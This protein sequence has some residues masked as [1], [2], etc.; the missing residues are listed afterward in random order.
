LRT[1]E[2][3]MTSTAAVRNMDDEGY[4]FARGLDYPAIVAASEKV[5]WTVD[6]VFRDRWF[7]RRQPI[8]PPSWI[9]AEKLSFL[10]DR[11]QLTLNH[12]RAFSYVHL[13]GNFEE[14]LTPHLSGIV[15]RESHDDRAHLRAL[16]RFG[17]EE[18]KHQQLFQRAERALETSCG[19]RFA[20]HFDDAK[21]AVTSLTKSILERPPLARFLMVLALEWGTQRHY[22]ESV[23]NQR[24]EGGDPLYVDILKAHWA[25]EAQHTKTDALEIARLAEGMSADELSVAF[26]DLLAIAGLVDGAF[27]DQAT[28][29]VETL[30]RVN[31][32]TFAEAER[33]ELRATLHA[34]LSAIMA[35]VG[36]SHP[37]FV[38]V[39][40]ELSTAG[41]AKLGIVER[42]RPARSMRVA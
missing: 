13:L 7:A 4:A 9:G 2:D 37:K 12:C 36:L 1:A 20:R 41:A 30:E 5:A 24:A 29:E 17:D 31:R 34:S 19:I 8:V 14:F 6:D 42:D 11:D 22:V 28:K 32:R 26:D 27:S 16:C 18:L 10:D 33:T 35:G 40:C 25:E 23:R 3:M 15:T 38:A 21:V 39:A